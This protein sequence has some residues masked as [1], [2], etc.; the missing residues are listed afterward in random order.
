[1]QL[2]N[3]VRQ[4]MSETLSMIWLVLSL[5]IVGVTWAYVLAILNSR[6]AGFSWWDQLANCGRFV[7]L[8][9][10]EEIPALRRKYARILALH[11]VS[12][13]SALCAFALFVGTQIR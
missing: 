6:G 12:T 1:M 2:N 5:C 4:K 11:A 13:V 7:K 10:A 9:R 8:I 3:T